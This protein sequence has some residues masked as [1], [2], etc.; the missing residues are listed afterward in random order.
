MKRFWAA[1]RAHNNNHSTRAPARHASLLEDE[2]GESTDLVQQPWP[3]YASYE[4]QHHP[5]SGFPEICSQHFLHAAKSRIDLFYILFHLRNDI[6]R[7]C[8]DWNA[9]CENLNSDFFVTTRAN[10]I[11]IISDITILLVAIIFPS[12]ICKHHCTIWNLFSGSIIKSPLS[13]KFF[14]SSKNLS[15]FRLRNWTAH[16][17]H[18][19]IPI[20]G[21]ITSKASPSPGDADTSP[22]GTTRRPQCQDPFDRH[23]A[24]CADCALS[25]LSPPFISTAPSSS[26]SRVSASTFFPHF[27]R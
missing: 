15:K 22:M 8:V 7:R 12:L 26:P 9:N 17:P 4:D 24:P 25:P 2:P 11:P 21:L 1:V 16:F 18:P 3:T 10:D 13:N 27:S 20:R 6:N 23:C 19:I 5:P 14:H